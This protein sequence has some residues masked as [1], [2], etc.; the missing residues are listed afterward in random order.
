MVTLTRFNVGGVINFA[1]GPLY[2]V[3][4][5]FDQGVF[6]PSTYNGEVKDN[7]VKSTVA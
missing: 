4:I 1:A 3:T 6:L 2:G 5:L 7:R